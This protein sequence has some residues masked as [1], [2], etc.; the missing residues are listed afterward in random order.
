MFDKELSLRIFSKLNVRYQKRLSN[1]KLAKI[2]E[3]ND[4]FSKY[5]DNVDLN[6]IRK[7]S[8]SEDRLDKIKR[9]TRNNDL[10]ASYY[11]RYAQEVGLDRYYKKAN[12]VDSC[13]SLYDVDVY[14]LLKIKDVKRTNLCEDRFCDNCQANRA[15]NRE[16]KFT[17]ILDT[18]SLVYDLYHVVFTV[19]NV[20]GELLKNTLNRM[21]SKFTYLVRLLCCNVKIKGIDFSKYGFKGVI[22]A[23]EIT[24]NESD[25]KLH[26]HFHCILV[27]Q[28]GLK[29]DKINKYHKNEYSF[30]N[31]DNG[32][33]NKPKIYYFSDF[34]ILLQKIWRLL[35]DGV[36]ITKQNIDTLSIGYDVYL[37]NARGK[38]H[39]IFKYA[40]KGLFKNSD[41][42]T[43]CYD[44]F[45]YLLEAL[46]K[47]H[48][49]QG[50]GIFHGFKLDVPEE[51]ES[52]KVYEN[53]ICYLRGTEEPVRV[54]EYFENV[55]ANVKKGYTYISRSSMKKIFDLDEED[56]TKN[57]VK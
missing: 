40:T 30:N 26:P 46:E 28:K 8:L 9:R 49:I 3:C 51:F 42:A 55:L 4:K 24:R 10:I 13:C 38:Y 43:N 25:K 56:E 36:Q 15:K 29:L 41:S 23:L 31:K 20:H 50:Y 54:Y 7:T 45:V 48:I 57:L 35:I 19:P 18:L 53:T 11:N 32:Q 39:Q 6:E 44:E 16:D 22:R 27:C 33:K 12:R 47:R 1:K 2:K 52:D 21:F 14:S 5:V 37:N 34:E 17:P